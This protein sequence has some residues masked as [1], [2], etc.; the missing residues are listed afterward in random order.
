M[1]YRRGTDLLIEILPEL[2]R[3]HADIEVLV[4]GDGVKRRALEKII[5]RFGLQEKVKLLGIIG[6]H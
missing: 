3:R 2:C 4:V 5:E 1:M 6:D